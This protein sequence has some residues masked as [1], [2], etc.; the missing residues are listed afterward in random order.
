MPQSSLVTSCRG[1]IPAKGRGYILSQ[2]YPKYYMGGTACSWLITVPSPQRLVLRV[3]D[4]ALRGS[5]S[6][7]RCPD[8]LGLDN[9]LSLCGE[10]DKEVVFIPQTSKVAVVFNTST[11][12]Q[13]IFPGRGVLL[14]YVTVGCRPFSPPA[15]TSL[16]W[17]NLTH[18]RYRCHQGHV[19]LPSLATFTTVACIG[20]TYTPL[21]PC[22][23]V[24]L[25]LSQGNDSVVQALRRRN[26]SQQLHLPIAGRAWFSEVVLPALITTAIVI[27]SLAGI[28]V[29][30]L[31]HRHM[32]QPGYRPEEEQSALHSEINLSSNFITQS[33]AYLGT[34][35][36]GNKN[37]V[38][39]TLD[40][41]EMF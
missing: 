5:D 31:L 32:N 12:L 11:N 24:H 26:T 4:L 15:S 40:N 29:L 7:A 36:R 39:S 3:L 34:L 41:Y 37:I 1:P 6:L 13:H 2:S 10:L 21:P 38:V 30:L 14:E 19:F 27:L 8:S 35:Q 23:S 33:P 25:L 28:I 20:D 16:D 17:Y 22:T 9:E 18:A